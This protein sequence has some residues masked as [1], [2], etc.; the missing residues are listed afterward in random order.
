MT[1]GEA[2]SAIKLRLGFYTKKDA[3]IRAE[4]SI[5]QGQL[6][7]GVKL[8][9]TPEFPR[10]RGSFKPWFLVSEVQ[11]ALTVVDEDRVPVPAAVTGQHL[12]F[13]SE[14]EDAALWILDPDAEADDAWLEL[15]K[16]P[17]DELQTKW[18]GPGMPKGYAVLGNYYRLRHVPDDAYTLKIITHN[19]D[20]LLTADS[21]AGS[22]NKWLTYAPEV[23][24]AHTGITLATALRDAG[25]LKQFTDTFN[26]GVEALYLATEERIHANRRYVMGG[27]D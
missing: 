13:L 10:P 14:V 11:S 9:I 6:E 23:L 18:P 5:S 16:L 15:Q 8:P 12:G 22:T 3:E 19:A 21:G 24:W 2:I 20:L 27:E 7:R 1:R 17:F 25:A 26:Q 4:L